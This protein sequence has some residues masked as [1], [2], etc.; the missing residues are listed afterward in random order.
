MWLLAT[1]PVQGAGAG[2]DVLFPLLEFGWRVL[3]PWRIL[4]TCVMCDS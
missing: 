4:L 1:L 3:L 2:V